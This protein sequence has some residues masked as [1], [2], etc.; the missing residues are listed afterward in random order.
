MVDEK[1]LI[2]SIEVS[3]RKLRPY[4]EAVFRLVEEYA[5]PMYGTEGNSSNTFQRQEKYLNLSK[6]AVSAYMTLLASNRPRVLLSTAKKELKPFAKRY[7]TA[8]NNLLEEIEIEK[9]ISQWV[10]D[11]FFWIGIVKVH[12]GDSGEVINEGDITMNR[13][14]IR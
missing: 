10:R 1:K 4:R 12:M 7:Q 2:S 6:Q 5:G 8:V 11:A 14:A 13:Q 9:T 3:Y